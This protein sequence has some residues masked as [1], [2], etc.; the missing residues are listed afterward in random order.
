MTDLADVVALDASW[1]ISEATDTTPAMSVQRT[2][3]P[4]ALMV[5]EQR[6][7]DGGV[8]RATGYSLESGLARQGS[9]A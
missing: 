1:P 4:A 8:V 2:P 9:E 7:E 6:A 5:G 3:P